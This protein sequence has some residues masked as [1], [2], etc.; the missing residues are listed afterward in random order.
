RAFAAAVAAGSALL[1]GYSLWGGIKE[2]AMA[3]LLVLVAALVPI[4]LKAPGRR[5]A[6]PLAVAAAATVGAQSAAGA[7]W[8][9]VPA[10]VVAGLLIRRRDRRSLEA[11]SA[12]VVATLVLAIPSISAATTWL[13]HTGAFTSDTEFGNL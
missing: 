1:Y 6:L 11:G 4:F 2:L 10:V 9:L 8:L 12:L 13:G 5:A 7:V 3:M